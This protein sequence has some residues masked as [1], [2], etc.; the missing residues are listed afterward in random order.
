MFPGS[1][2]PR[3]LCWG[4]GGG[5]HIVANIAIYV[6]VVVVS[7]FQITLTFLYTYLYTVIYYIYRIFGAT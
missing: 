2:V 5:E 4:G 6:G 3:V 1:Y 7:L